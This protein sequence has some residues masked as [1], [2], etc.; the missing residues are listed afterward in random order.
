MDKRTAICEYLKKTIL[1]KAKPSTAE[2]CS[3]F[4]A[5]MGEIFDARSA[6]CAK[7]VFPSAAMKPV[8]T[9]RMIR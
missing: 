8:I 3:G 6:V 4:F 9:M 7:T 5:L 1:E 2:S